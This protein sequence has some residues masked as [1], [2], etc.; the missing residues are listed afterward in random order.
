[1]IKVVTLSGFSSSTT[2]VVNDISVEGI[3]TLNIDLQSF[4]KNAYIMF[5]NCFW[6][7]YILPNINEFATDQKVLILTNTI[8]ISLCWQ[9]RS[10]FQPPDRYPANICWSSTRLQRNNFTSSKTSWTRLE[11]VLQR[12]LEDVFK[13]CLEDVFNTPS[14]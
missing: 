8:Q 10:T 13:T 1:M 3:N 2:S 12:C 14:A 4:L 9:G 11:D 5:L 6:N 7:F